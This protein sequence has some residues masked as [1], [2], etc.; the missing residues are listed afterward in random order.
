[1]INL[2]VF[3]Q[4]IVSNQSELD[5]AVNSATAGSEIILKNGTWN[6]V[7]IDI[8]AVGSSSNPITIQAETAGSVFMEGN[9]DIQMGGKY[10]TIE[11]LVFQNASGLV[12]DNERIDPIIEFR[13]S[14]NSE[15]NYCTVS[16]IKIDSYNGTDSQAEATFKWIILYGANNAIK[17]CSFVGKY[18]V[19]SIINDNR[20]STIANYNKIHHNYFA[21]RT[22]VGDV[23]ELNDQDAIRIGNSSTS[24]SDSFTEV[25]ANY[26]NNWTG[27]IEIISNKSGSN[28]Y[29]NNT[30]RDY[31]G[32]LTLRHGNKC[33]VYSNYFF[34]NGNHT[35][36]GIRVI[37]EGHKIYNNYIEGVNSKKQSG[38]TSGA[39]GGINITNGREN[40]ELNGYYQVIDAQIINNTFVDCDYG[41][42]VGTQVK[43]DLTLA[44]KNTEITN[45]IMLNSSSKAIQE[46]TAP[47]GSST[48]Q[49]NI[50]KDGSW[51]I[52]TDVNNNIVTDL[53]LLIQD[54]DNLF[55]RL[56]SGSP[57]LDYG[58]SFDFVTE[59][60]T[61]DK[62][63]E[64]IDA[65]A[66]ELNSK[67]E[68]LPYTD[69][70][71]GVTVG[72]GATQSLD[73]ELPLNSYDESRGEIHIY[74]TPANKGFIHIESNSK[75]I[76]SYYL[77][78]LT[79]KMIIN[80]SRLGVTK[81]IDVSQVNT[82][83]YVLI[84]P[85]F[86]RYKVLIQNG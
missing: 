30:F 21:D 59:D 35:T 62:R 32:S 28:K 44:P 56:T 53:E 58:I 11:G 37:G 3:G 63:D 33:E 40:T 23:N 45:N 72:F 46:T 66:E 26:F 68:N 12:V 7:T 50:T 77:I 86:G 55:Y 67:G 43:D 82:G 14:N 74:P 19:G 76:D 61:G 2:S 15:C 34:A 9:S 24:L 10:I 13:D 73:P 6:N 29:Y 38:S 20:N 42:R 75:F 39:T 47:T 18:G 69:E 70:H 71:V 4:T 79:G 22:P 36:A 16:N 1:M 52:N 27:E 60:I 49:N 31:H 85:Q 57:A 48:Y 5:D 81:Q 80:E 54:E 25:Y 65:G 64:N 84:I 51:D 17:Y 41:I 83:Y 8:N 78:D